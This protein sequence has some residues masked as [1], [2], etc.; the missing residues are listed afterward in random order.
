VALVAT[1]LPFDTLGF[2]D[3]VMPFSTGMCSS[4]TGGN[5]SVILYHD[6]DNGDTNFGMIETDTVGTVLNGDFT[7]GARFVMVSGS[8]LV[9]VA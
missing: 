1:P 9:A 8:Y 6:S 5:K 2:S 3:N 7:N 4:A